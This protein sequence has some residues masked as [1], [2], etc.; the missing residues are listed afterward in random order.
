MGASVLLL[1]HLAVTQSLATYKMSVTMLPPMPVSA[2]KFE[3]QPGPKAVAETSPAYQSV[4]ATLAQMAS[5][6]HGDF[7]DELFQEGEWL[8]GRQQARM[9]VVRS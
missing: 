3:K 4:R 6:A 9:P 2:P 5:H 1:R 7:R 8:K